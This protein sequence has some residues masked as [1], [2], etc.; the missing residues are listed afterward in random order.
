MNTAN[1]LYR[2][3]VLFVVI[4]FVKAQLHVVSEMPLVC[5][6]VQVDGANGKLGSIDVSSHFDITC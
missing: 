5:R 2:H 1:V 3:L 6:T 4:H